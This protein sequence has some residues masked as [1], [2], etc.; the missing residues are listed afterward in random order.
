MF[1]NPAISR[2]ITYKL[3]RQRPAVLYITYWLL[4]QRLAVLYNLVTLTRFI[5]MDN[6]IHIDTTSME[7]SNLYFTGFPIKIAVNDIFLSL[8]VFSSSFSSRSLLFA[9]VPVYQY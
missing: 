7:L 9:K 8:M 2:N 1:L 6:P 3:L 4:R 5:L